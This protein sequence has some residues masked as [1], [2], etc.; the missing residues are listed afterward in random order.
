MRKRITLTMIFC[1]IAF[2]VMVSDGFCKEEKTQPAKPEEKKA[3]EKKEMTRDEVLAVLKSDLAKSDEIFDVIPELKLVK[4][5][6]GET[7]YTYNGIRLEDMSKEDADKLLVRVRQ[8]LTRLNT[9]RIQMQLESAR[10]A[11]RLRAISPPRAPLV[12]AAIPQPPRTPPSPP[13]APRV[14]APPPPAPTRR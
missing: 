4:G 12:P 13:S 1:I 11:E 2:N 8:N 6:Q 10:S 9:E 5:P 3:P 7:Y 14:P